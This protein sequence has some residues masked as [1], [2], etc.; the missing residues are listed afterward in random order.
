MSA[1]TRQRR[2]RLI[3][4]R[5]LILLSLAMLAALLISTRTYGADKPRRVASLSLCVDE[6]LLSLAEPTQVAAVSR[7]AAD[8]RYS[9]VWQ[10]AQHTPQHDGLAEQLVALRPDL[11]LAAE[12]EQ[13]KATTLLRQLGYDVRIVAT[14]TTLADVPAQWREVA[15]WLGA[16]ARAEALL[17]NWQQKLAQAKRPPPTATSPLALSLAPNGYTPGQQSL[18]NELLHWTG[19]RTAADVLGLRYDSELTLEQILLLNADVLF[20]EEQHGNRDALAFRLLDHPAL[21]QQTTRRIAVN[22]ADWLCPDLG[23]AT[24]AQKLAQ[25]QDSADIPRK[26]APTEV[27]P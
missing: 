3:T 24:M 10:Q 11:L 12:Y 8:P 1:T 16:E 4:G 25:V 17:A 7:L 26:A 9:R 6:L 18:K 23:L 27:A 14:A 21:Q 19:Y 2:S 5:S 22:S 20:L 15:T 13:G